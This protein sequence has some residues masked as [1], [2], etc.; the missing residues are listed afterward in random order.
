M[1]LLS[2]LLGTA[3]AQNQG[4]NPFVWLDSAITD[5]GVVTVSDTWVPEHDGFFLTKEKITDGLANTFWHSIEPDQPGQPS[6]MN[7]DLNES[8]TINGVTI[9]VRPDCCRDRYNNMCVTLSDIDGSSLAEKCTSSDYGEPYLTGGDPE[10]DTEYEDI[11]VPFNSV[12]GVQSIRVSFSDDVGQ[13]RTLIVEGND[14][15]SPCLNEAW[16]VDA[17]GNCQPKPAHFRLQC[18]ASGMVV[19]IDDVVFPDGEAVNLED[20]SCT[21]TKTDGTWSINTALDSCQT[22]MVVETDSNAVETLAFSNTVKFNWFS[23]D[24]QIYTQNLVQVGFTCNYDSTYDDIEVTDVTVVSENVD[25]DLQDVDGVFTFGLVQYMDNAMSDPADADDHT[26]LGGTM[27][28]QL[29]MDNPVSNLDWVVTECTVSDDTLGLSYQLIDNQCADQNLQVLATP[30]M[31]GNT[32]SAVNLSFLSFK[33]TQNHETERV[34]MK[35]R[36]SV[37]VCDAAD[38]NSTCNTN[39]C[40]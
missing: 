39:N 37:T 31:N 28:F 3:L 22:T 8:K 6:W 23:A 30:Q 15:P 33:F 1:K 27:Y 20:S 10:S 2:A 21:G 16:E 26:P 17:D 7:Y 38:P 29:T 9:G 34:D 40:A 35:L 12:N 24:A 4:E 13:I 19:E 18:S 25:S 14:D 36:C 5:N 11:R 32:Q